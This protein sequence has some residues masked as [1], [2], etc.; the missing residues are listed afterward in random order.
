VGN[1]LVD[2]YVKSGSLIEA[3]QVFDSLKV[4]DVVS[5][6]SLIA[7]YA[8]QG[9]SKAVF[10][11]FGK[12]G[13]QGICPDAVV[14]QSVL[15]ACDHSGL[16][17]MGRAYFEA[18]GREYG[19]TPTI[20]HHNAM[21]DILARAGR[22][23]EVVEMLEKMPLQPDQV[24]WLSVLSACRRWGNVKLAEKAF[25]NAVKLDEEDD[26]AFLLMCNIYL[27]AE[28]WEDCRS[29]DM[30]KARGQAEDVMQN[31]QDIVSDNVTR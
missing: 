19:R 27:D 21:V 2:S 28:M 9:M 30:M 22:F 26:A 4:Q 29:I 10:H 3:R 8:F 12:M 16:V 23:E 7:G 11:L 25:V 1:V 5:W 15:T 18:I 17:D 31:V 13:E 24:T 6:T 20:S 14:L